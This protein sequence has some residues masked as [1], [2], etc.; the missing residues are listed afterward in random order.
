VLRGAVERAEPWRCGLA[1]FTPSLPRVYSLNLL[2]VSDPQGLSAAELADEADRVQGAAGVPHRKLRVPH[3]AHAA[4][5]AGAF[6][7]MG[8]QVQRHVAMA[9]RRDPDRPASAPVDEVDR[10]GIRP[11]QETYLRSEAFVTDEEILRQLLEQEPCIER[12]VSV[13]YFAARVDGEVV[14]YAKLYSDGRVGQVED[15]ATLPP[16]RRRGLARA[17]VLAAADASRADGHELTFIVADD[18]DW[19]KELY[20]RLGFDRLGL[21]HN[22][23]R[24]PGRAT[25]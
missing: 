25:A 23:I 5:L 15:V 7:T 24:Q 20:A 3:E 1:L 18:D 2:E 6:A 12:A 11:A 16:H 17:V 4:G 19:P 14:S 13:R 8:W 21:V 22:F 10:A 9:W